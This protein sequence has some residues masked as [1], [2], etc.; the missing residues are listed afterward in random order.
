MAV[1]LKNEEY[2]A[3]VAQRDALKAAME[4]LSSAGVLEDGQWDSRDAES[5]KRAARLSLQNHSDAPLSATQ[6]G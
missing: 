3:L 6:G 5:A 2:A 4:L 1:Q